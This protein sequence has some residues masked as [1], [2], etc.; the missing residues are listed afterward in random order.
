MA[1]FAMSMRRVKVEVSCSF[2]ARMKETHLAVND[3][4]ETKTEVHVLMKYYENCEICNE[5]KKKIFHYRSNIFKT[6]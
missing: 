1:S 3:L 2:P 5:K 6:R 4:Y